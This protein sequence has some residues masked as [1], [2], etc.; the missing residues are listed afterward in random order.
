MD[1]AEKWVV[2]KDWVKA[3]MDEQ[4]QWNGNRDKEDAFEAVLDKM[5]ALG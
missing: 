2:L 4:N 5:E 3:Q 1:Y